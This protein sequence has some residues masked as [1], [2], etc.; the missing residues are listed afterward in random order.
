MTAK[1]IHEDTALEAFLS[2]VTVTI[3]FFA[4][5]MFSSGIMYLIFFSDEGKLLEI[6]KRRRSHA[7]KTV[8]VTERSSPHSP[9]TELI[10]S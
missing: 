8:E 1:K 7:M 6:M 4:L 10:R 3:L 9:D 2:T 5:L